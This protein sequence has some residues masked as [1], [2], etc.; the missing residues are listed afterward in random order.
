MKPRRGVSFLSFVHILHLSCNPWQEK[1]PRSHSQWDAMLRD[2]GDVWVSI[3][4]ADF[5]RNVGSRMERPEIKSILRKSSLLWLVP[6]LLQDGCSTPD[7]HCPI[8][9]N[10]FFTSLIP[11]ICFAWEDWL[12]NKFPLYEVSLAHKRSPTSWSILP[13]GV[14]TT[15]RSPKIWHV[16]PHWSPYFILY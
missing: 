2:M 7:Y 15:L 8:H 11:P 3:F 1:W 5:A 9:R 6:M 13:S 16:L 10:D 12:Y 4:S 14:H